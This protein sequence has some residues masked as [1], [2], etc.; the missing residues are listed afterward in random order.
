MTDPKQYH[1]TASLASDCP[2]VDQIQVM[3][4]LFQRLCVQILHSPV[5]QDL[6]TKITL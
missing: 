4:Q 5:N 6:E 1:Y 2:C 3:Y